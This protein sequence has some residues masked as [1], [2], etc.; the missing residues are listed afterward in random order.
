ML[1]IRNRS[2]KPAPSAWSGGIPKCTRVDPVQS[3][4]L[5]A[6][7]STLAFTRA[8][9]ATKPPAVHPVQQSGGMRTTSSEQYFQ[10]RCSP[11]QKV[12]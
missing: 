8:R 5:D 4:R 12:Y 10:Q 7:H 11:H 3:D 6:G 9:R 2:F 1:D